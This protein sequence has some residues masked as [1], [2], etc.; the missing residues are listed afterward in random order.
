LDELQ[1]AVYKSENWITCACGN[2]CDII[3]R[4]GNGKPDD[5]LL[6]ELGIRFF[7]AI[8]AMLDDEGEDFVAAREYAK[9]ILMDIEKRSAELIAEIQANGTSNP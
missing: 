9:K 5:P 8:R 6:L 3:P 4:N 2:Q 7:G 1:L